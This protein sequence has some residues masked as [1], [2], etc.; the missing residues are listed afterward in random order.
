MSD[1]TTTPQVTVQVQRTGHGCIVTLLWFVFVGWWASA[2]WSFI[3]WFLILLIFTMPF[4]LIMINKLPRIVS[5]RQ[6]STEFTAS[7]EGT[8][9]VIRETKLPQRPMLL[10][11]PYFLV[12]GWWLSFAWMTLAWLASLTLIGLPLAIWMYNRVPAI[13]TLKRY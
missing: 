9:T 10:R 12:I 7:T 13:T 1:Q 4:G 5:L 11:I 8:A 3:A 2:I 6:L